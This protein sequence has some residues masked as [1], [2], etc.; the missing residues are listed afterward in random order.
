MIETPFS[1]HRRHPH[2]DV[3]A[4][5][6]AFLPPAEAVMRAPPSVVA[7]SVSLAI[8]GFAIIMILWAVLS[9]TEVV[10]TASGRV[11]PTGQVKVVQAAEGGVVRAINVR[12]GQRVRRGDV[13][14]KLDATTTEADRQRLEREYQEASVEVARLKAELGGEVG[15]FQPPDGMDAGL[16]AVQRNLLRSRLR[17]REERMAALDNEVERLTAE[18]EAIR[19]QV[20]KLSATLPLARRRLDKLKTLADKQYLSEF[21]YLQAKM[22]LIGQEKEWRISRQRLR[23]AEAALAAAVRRR[24]QDAA[25]WEADLMAQ[26]TEASRRRDAAAQERVK[27]I[28][29]SALQTVTAPVDGVVQQLSVHTVG[30]VVTAAQALMVIVPEDSGLEVEAQVLNRDVGALQ[31]GQRVSVKVEAYSF[32]RHGA[33][34]GELEWVGT[35]AV[36]DPNRGLV[37]PVK[38]A[39]HDTRMPNRVNGKRNAIRPGMSVTA[40]I[41]VGERRV[42]EYFLGPILRYRD[43]SLREL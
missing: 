43:E 15:A 21:D 40:D 32:T 18:R 14:I 29:R 42:I 26:L 2:G 35:D 4:D 23:E 1:G 34:Q 13:L 16:V 24:D 37:Y 9:T 17:Q 20:E 36:A 39:L 22:E 41:V 11:V 19:L 30:G 5:A 28:Q 6:V 10:V 8:V 33:L 31:A 27:A 3:D 12:D 7:R 25:E 38:I